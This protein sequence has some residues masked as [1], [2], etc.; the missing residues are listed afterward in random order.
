MNR[1]VIVNAEPMNTC[2]VT[3]GVYFQFNKALGKMRII[4]DSSINKFIADN[5]LQGLAPKEFPCTPEFHARWG[6]SPPKKN[7]PPFPR[8]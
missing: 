2:D 4:H 5:D 1:K 6:L 7:Q 8:G 3:V